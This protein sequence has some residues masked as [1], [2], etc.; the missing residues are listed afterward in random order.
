[1]HFIRRIARLFTRRSDDA[2]MD[3]EMRFHLEMEERE[4]REAGHSAAEARRLARV[5]F[6]GV[7]RYREEGR[8][9]RGRAGDDAI[10]D[11]RYALRGV[12][13]RPGFA[14]A[15]VATLA[16]GIGA[17][18]AV[19][20][21]MDAVLLN[22]LPFPAAD[23]LARV[24]VWFSGDEGALSPAEY[25]D[26][27]RGTTEV[28][29]A[30]GAY[31]LGSATVAGG[32]ASAGAAGAGAG[33][34][35][36]AERV[37]AAYVAAE[38]FAAIG[39]EPLLGRPFTAEEELG[40][41]YA[42]LVTEGYWR[43]RLGADPGAVGRP[44]TIDGH[45]WTIV[46]VMPSSF[47]L[48]E[49]L[50]AGTAPELILPLGI[51]PD[52]TYRRGSHFLQ[53]VARLADGVTLDRAT[54][55][56]EGVTARFSADFPD[57]YEADMGFR[58]AAV[59]LRE[60]VV[61]DVRAAVRVAFAAVLLVLL[62][63]AANVAALLL[64]RGE[65]RRGEIALRATLGA[66]RPR[67]V[68]QLLAETLVLG[69][70]GGALGLALAW[71][72]L[73]GLV[74]LDPAGIPRLEEVAL[75]GRAIAFAGGLSLLCGALFGLLPALR[76]APEGAAGAL[77]EAGTRVTAGGRA[78]RRSLVVAEIGLA[79]ALLT[80]AGLLGRTMGELLAVDTGLR[81]DDVVATEF[82]VPVAAYPEEIQVRDFVAAAVAGVAGLPEIEAAGAVTNLPLA[83]GIG[84]VGVAIPGRDVGGDGTL[85]VDWQAATPGY[86]RAVGLRLV[87]GR[88]FDATDRTDAPGAVVI[89]RTFAE[90][91]WPA[92]D[93]LGATVRLS[94]ET[95]PGEARIVGVVEDVKHEGP[96]A[97]ATLQIYIPHRQFGFWY[98][99]GPARG[100][101]LVARA[102]TGA[103]TAPA[104][105]RGSFA[106]LDASVGLGE[107]ITLE[108]AYRDALAGPRFLA[109]L[110]AAF[111]AVALL[112]AA[113]GVY[114][115]IA[116][117][118]GQRRR[119]FGIRMAL[120]ARAR[121]VAAEVVGEGAALAAVGVGL[122][123]AGALVLSRALR[124][125]LFGVS[126][127]DPL[128]LAAGAAVLLAVAL[129]ASW[130]P[131][132]RAVR[133]DPSEALRQE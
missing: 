96:A 8:E 129:L 95:A 28:F 50:V 47:R 59:P 46:G 111:A 42:A 70:L 106:D 40:A 130:I 34:G 1:M 103:R 107:F 14:A 43:T 76:L 83:E 80:A 133:V 15:V 39:Q 27:R 57:D 62:V 98:N 58:A 7:E 125:L 97:P 54:A 88:W 41:G 6:G 9:A 89:N 35:A 17:T 115:V 60:A 118:V 13:R 99:Q 44:L 94:A 132:R 48:P 109:A 71:L 104:A 67:L 68:R 131:A 65:S 66:R 81:L 108:G 16:V 121:R 123:L 63:G 105:I 33:A 127:S 87:A 4:L 100:M 51:H 64:A 77:R 10:R 79:L 82:T 110:M 3:E 45:P 92:G 53:S 61:G 72:A 90:T 49:H 93:A 31:A 114:G 55:A 101:T 112:L 24:Q 32:A 74:V 120:G 25:L 26:Y 52:T 86:D 56:I 23:R 102:R 124:S 20:S 117:G 116:Y 5:R 85:N 128:V 18:T 91:W 37:D 21:L 30:L 122:G 78:L 36:G 84:D 2:L 29:S 126:A 19:W 38:L 75:D 12:R 11:V 113:I 119:E 73:R 69:I 22:P